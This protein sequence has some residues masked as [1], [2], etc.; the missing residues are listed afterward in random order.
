[1]INDKVKLYQIIQMPEGMNKRERVSNDFSEI[2]I[3]I[4]ILGLVQSKL[5]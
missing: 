3:P 1:M 4:S 2:F 5:R